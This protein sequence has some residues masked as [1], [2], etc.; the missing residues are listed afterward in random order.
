[1]SSGSTLTT[2]TASAAAADPALG[3]TLLIHIVENGHS[4]EFECDG[5]TV[6]E[7]IQRSIECLCSVPAGDQL[8]LCRNVS[9]D[10]QQTLAYY[11]LPAMI[12]R[13]SSSINVPNPA[14]PSP[15]LPDDSHA[16]DNGKDPALK[17]LVSY[18]RQF[19]YHFQLA[20]SVYNSA[21]VKFEIC[22]RLLREQQV[23]ERA[24]DTARSNLD[25]TFRKMQQRYIDFVRCF[26]QQYHRHSEILANFERDVEKL[27]LI[28]LH[29]S[30]Q[31]DGRKCLMDLVKEGDVRK[32]ADV[33][34][35]SH[36]QFEVK[37]SKLKSNF[38]N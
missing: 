36:Q 8:L 1:M 23:Q 24:L 6:V 33:C 20:N 4:F 25:H 19:R 28:K 35:I 34:L 22:K 13:S 10:S 18:E 30:L 26:S 9:L 5:A 38:G 32:W 7:A 27:R 16:F 17:A 2:S 14:L 37:V 3:R 15:P 21:Q 29:P 11:K 12:G 31:S